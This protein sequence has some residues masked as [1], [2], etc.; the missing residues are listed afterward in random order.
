MPAENDREPG[1]RQRYKVS[2]CVGFSY[3][4]DDCCDCEAFPGQID[5]SEQWPTPLELPH[6]I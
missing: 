6:A 1:K 4:Q 5:E 3:G 2:A